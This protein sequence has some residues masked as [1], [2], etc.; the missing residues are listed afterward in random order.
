MTETV[1]GGPIE[2]LVDH[3]EI[4][5]DFKKIPKYLDSIWS[6]KNDCTM[7]QKRKRHRMNSHPIIHCPTSSGVIEVSERVSAAERASKVSGA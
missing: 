7:G 4:D 3:L 2:R 5:Y 1:L 6:G